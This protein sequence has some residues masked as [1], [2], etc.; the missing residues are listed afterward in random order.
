MVDDKL[1]LR[2]TLERRCDCLHFLWGRH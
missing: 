1:R 2:K